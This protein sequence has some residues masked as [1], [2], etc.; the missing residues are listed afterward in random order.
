MAHCPQLSWLLGPASGRVSVVCLCVI[1]VIL[2][3]LP[4]EP[5]DAEPLTAV[6]ILL[7]PAG[8]S[9]LIAAN[10]F[11]QCCANWPLLSMQVPIS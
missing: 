1:R 3:V 7:L 11:T 5:R 4:G 8:G 9:P 10:T 6:N 2:P